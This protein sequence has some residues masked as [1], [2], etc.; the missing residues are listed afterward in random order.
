MRCDAATEHN[1][2]SHLKAMED[3]TGEEE[4]G[5]ERGERVQSTAK[6]NITSEEQKQAD[7]RTTPPLSS[8][9]GDTAPPPERE[10]PLGSEHAPTPASVGDEYHG[11]LTEVAHYI[12]EAIPVQETVVV[13]SA[14]TEEL[15][16]GGLG[17]CAPPEAT[18]MRPCHFNLLT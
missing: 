13:H 15:V 9:H 18:I 6:P 5:K 2:V 17:G 7:K 14:A 3:S 12:G 10:Q 11:N 8:H 16:T 1:V 4:D